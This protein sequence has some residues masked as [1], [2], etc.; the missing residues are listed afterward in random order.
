VILGGTTKRQDCARPT[1]A[2]DNAVF[3]WR[4]DWP[5]GTPE[6][7]LDCGL[8]PGGGS[9]EVETQAH[10]PIVDYTVSLQVDSQYNTVEVIAE[11][12]IY[13]DPP[14]RFNPLVFANGVLGRDHSL[15]AFSDPAS[16]PPQNVLVTTN[17]RGATTTTYLVP[18]SEL[19]LVSQLRK[20][21]VPDPVADEM[22]TV[23]RPMVGQGLRPQR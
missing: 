22:N 5:V 18:A 6:E 12:D 20:W 7:V 4:G 8:G 1:D 19:P 9:F 15:A 11:Y 14:D 3:G 17:S 23:M 10:L 13:G 21:G 2:S 16:V